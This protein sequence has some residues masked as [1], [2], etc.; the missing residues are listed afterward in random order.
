[1]LSSATR[2]GARSVPIVV[3]FG[4]EPSTCR[5][6]ASMSVL[7]P[8]D[9]A[10][11]VVGAGRANWAA[12]ASFRNLGRP[13]FVMPRP[14]RSRRLRAR[15]TRR[16]V[17]AW[18]P[19]RVTDC[20]GWPLLARPP[21]IPGVD[22]ERVAAAFC[23][24]CRLDFLA[25]VEPPKVESVHVD[26]RVAVV[27]RWP[28]R[29]PVIDGVGSE[30]SLRAPSYARCRSQ[31]RRPGAAWG[32]WGLRGVTVRAALDLRTRSEGRP[33]GAWCSVRGRAPR[34]RRPP[35]VVRGSRRGRRRGWLGIA[36]MPGGLRPGSPGSCAGA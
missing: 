3:G 23:R 21:P 28:T 29:T 19:A 13:D 31:T 27:R 22:T 7:L 26:R 2:G 20:A 8:E 14:P 10:I 5:F 16:S 6:M 17:L 24:G 9:R 36:R 35:S 11:V 30:R 4:D 18:T 33:V 34:G 15:L 1:M 25:V 32:R 12:R